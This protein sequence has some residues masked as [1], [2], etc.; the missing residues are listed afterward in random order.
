MR[1]QEV[2]SLG[3]LCVNCGSR[4]ACIMGEKGRKFNSLLAILVLGSY[5]SIYLVLPRDKMAIY[6]LLF[7][8]AS[9]FQLQ[10]FITWDQE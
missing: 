9:T 8:T 1:K 10:M 3:M 6:L 7:E 5:Y 2:T 4:K